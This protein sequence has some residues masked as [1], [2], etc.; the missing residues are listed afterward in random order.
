MKRSASRL[1]FAA[2]GTLLVLCSPLWA[3]PS[4]QAPS[5]YVSTATDLKREPSRSSETLESLAPNS[6]VISIRRQGSWVQVQ[7]GEQVGWV[8]MLVVRSGTPGAQRKGE[9]GLSRLFNIARSGSSGA[10]T[11]TGVRGL[12]KEQIKNAAPDPAELAK[13]DAWIATDDQARKL[14]DAKPTLK[15]TSLAYV[16][17]DGSA[18][19]VQ[20]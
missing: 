10:V 2:V 20:P 3:Q 13:L 12:D 19:E 6:P 4:P 5:A 14:A 18:E 17:A 16:E 7:H 11:T 15:A 8:R 9:G 1:C